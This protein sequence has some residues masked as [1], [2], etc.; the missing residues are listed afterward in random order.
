MLVVGAVGVLVGLRMFVEVGTAV[1]AAVRVTAG[2]D[3]KTRV[4]VRR[5]ALQAA[6]AA[7]RAKQ[8]SRKALAGDEMHT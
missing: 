1:A 5:I 6:R 4:G 2:V 8:N 3:S 7:I